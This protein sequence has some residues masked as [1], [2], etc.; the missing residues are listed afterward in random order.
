MK[1]DAQSRKIDMNRKSGHSASIKVYFWGANS[2]IRIGNIRL[3][4]RGK[5]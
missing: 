5:G 2:V 4:P 3:K 1:G